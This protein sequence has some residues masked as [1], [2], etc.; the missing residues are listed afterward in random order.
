MEADTK[1]KCAV[2]MFPSDIL[3]QILS[4]LPIDVISNFSTLSKTT[5]DLTLQKEIW[6][7]VDLSPVASRF[8]DSRIVQLLSRRCSDVDIPLVSVIQHLNLENCKVNNETVAFI[9]ASNHRLRSLGLHGCNVS[10]AGYQT[11]ASSNSAQTLVRLDIRGCWGVRDDVIKLISAACPN[12]EDWRL[13]G[14]NLTDVGLY[15]IAKN[16]PKLKRLDISTCYDFTRRGVQAVLRSCSQLSVFLLRG[17]RQVSDDAFASE[18]SFDNEASLPLEVTDGVRLDDGHQAMHSAVPPDLPV[19]LQNV[20]IVSG[21]LQVL[22]L[23]ECRRLRNILQHVSLNF[24][25][26]VELSVNRCG[27]VDDDGVCALATTC[28]RLRKLDLG[29][30]SK[31]TDNAILAIANSSF[32]PLLEYLDLTVVELMTDKF[33][34]CLASACQQLTTLYLGGCTQL[35]VAVTAV[36]NFCRK[37]EVISLTGCGVDDMSMLHFFPAL[38]QLRVFILKSADGLGAAGVGAIKEAKKLRV[39]MLG[40]CPS[41]DDQTMTVIAR[42]C[43]NLQEITLFGCKQLKGKCFQKM[44]EEHSSLVPLLKSFK[45]RSCSAESAKALTDL[46]SKR[47]GLSISVV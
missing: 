34:V 16:C 35:K 10:D 44:A 4:W 1:V 19:Q 31:L 46:A 9:S 3:V 27:L 40:N 18:F 25:N 11:I 42:G 38:P 32:A 6:Q 14:V 15:A 39:L 22:D 17:C 33:A 21:G 47:K 20:N 8:S 41:L 23:S 37:L 7:H 2:D 30:C 43:S 26:L 5:R 28:R 45:L 29:H 12:I 36:A 24:P 13:S